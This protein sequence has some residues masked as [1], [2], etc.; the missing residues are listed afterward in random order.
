MF[1]SQNLHCSCEATSV[2]AQTLDEVSYQFGILRPLKIWITSYKLYGSIL[3]AEIP[4]WLE[5]TLI[6][7]SLFLQRHIFRTSEFLETL[8]EL[9]GTISCCTVRCCVAFLNPSIS[10][11]LQHCL[12]VVK[13][14]KSSVD[15]KTSPDFPSARGRRGLNFTLRVKLFVYKRFKKMHP[16]LIVKF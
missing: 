6:T 5:K 3:T 2:S 7:P 1:W 9:Y 12:V 10:E 8:D 14:Q 4:N 13:L 11:S 16:S 15:H